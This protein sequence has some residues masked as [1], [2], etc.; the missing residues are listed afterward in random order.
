MLPGD[1]TK[2]GRRVK[3]VGLVYNSHVLLNLN[4]GTIVH[5]RAGYVCPAS[6]AC[7]PTPADCPCPY[8]W[9]RQT[10]LKK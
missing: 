10:V 7:V 5:C 6:L 2:A 8:P 1:N 9:V 4:V 3:E